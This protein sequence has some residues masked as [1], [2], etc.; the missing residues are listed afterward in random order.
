MT[1]NIGGTACDISA[2][3]L[4]DC[5]VWFVS[6]DELRKVENIYK[7]VLS[8]VNIGMDDSIDGKVFLSKRHVRFNPTVQVV[9]M[10]TK[11]EYLAWGVKQDVWYQDSDYTRFRCV[12][13][14]CLISFLVCCRLKLS[15]YIYVS[16]DVERSV[17]TAM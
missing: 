4:S 8:N 7:H 12:M 10:A 11:E 9:L 5:W 13:M 3:A 16:I 1:Q 6:N 2:H 15:N 17:S 14:L